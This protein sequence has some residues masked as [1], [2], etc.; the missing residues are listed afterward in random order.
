MTENKSFYITTPIYYVNDSPHIGHAYTTIA[1]DVMARFKRLDG[2]DVKFLTGTDEHGQKV[3]K[4]AKKAGID[5]QSFTDEVSKRFRTLVKCPDEENENLLNVTNNDFIRTTERRHKKAAQAL[6][7]KIKEKGYIY[8]DSYAGW[9]SVR[10][11]AYYGEDELI[12]KDGVKLAPT[13]AEVE[14][15]EEESYFFKLSAFQKKLLEFYEKNPDFITPK[16][17]YNEVVSFVRGGKDLVQGALRDLSI[18]RTTFNWGVPVPDD[19]KHV[20]YVWIDALTN[21][22]TAIGFPD[23]KNTFNHYWGEGEQGKA[24]HVVGKD[25]LRFHA[26]YWP[27]FLMA[28][29]LPLPKKIVAHGW[30][31]IEGEKMSKSLGNVIAPK[32]LVDE[33]GIDQTRY[34]LMREVPF[35]NDGNFSKE[36]MAERINSDLA[37]NIGN[38]AQRTLSMIAKNCGGKV[39]NFVEKNLIHEHNLEMC[40]EFSSKISV[41]I[42]FFNF[43]TIA[44]CIVAIATDANISIDQK[45]PWTLKKEGKTEEMEHVLYVLAESIRCIAIMMQPFMPIAAKKLLLQLGYTEEDFNNEFGGVPFSQLSPENALVPGTELPKPQGVFPRIDTKAAA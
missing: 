1:C 18:S 31:T 37:N 2:Y 41:P 8:Q 4:A 7:N 13:G 19:E 11:E 40:Y 21:Y 22:L 30:W 42:N 24:V 28:A 44:E 12:E 14:W 43:N 45:A 33:Y 36:A 38:L 3:D 35:G 10:D 26:V 23:D 25:I 5:A 16:S 15:V 32:E 27:A 9:Y 17:R 34:F 6:W 20:M 39:P 29:D